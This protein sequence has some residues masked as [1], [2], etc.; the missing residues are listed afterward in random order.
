[1]Y[2]TVLLS[3]ILLVVSLLVFFLGAV[4]YSPNFFQQKKKDMDIGRGPNPAR[5]K[6]GGLINRQISPKRMKSGRKK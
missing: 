3:K 6:M 5:E 1:M 2:D 4:P